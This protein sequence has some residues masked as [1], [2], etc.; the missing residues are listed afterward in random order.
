MALHGRN[1]ERERALAQLL[2]HPR[3][4]AGEIISLDHVQRREACRTRQWPAAEC[5]AEIADGDALGE[6]VTD[7]DRGNRESGGQALGHRDRVGR[8]AI[9]LGGGERAEPAD[10]ALDLVEHE[11]HTVT[12]AGR[13]RRLQERMRAVARTG[14]PLHRLDDERGDRVVD[15]ALE[16]IHVVER[17]LLRQR[18]A[19]TA[20]AD[21]VLGTV[22][23]G[24]RRHG[25]TVPAAGDRHHE[26]ATGALPRQT[27]GILVRLS[28]RIAEEGTIESRAA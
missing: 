11:R 17:D 13:A 8:D 18:H 10:T 16:R 2:S 27:Q 25:T 4:I 7:R 9:E 1:A 5:A 14:H 6:E 26:L 19:G 28:A 21:L 20:R 24:Q 22:G 15:G 23:D 12:G 3:G